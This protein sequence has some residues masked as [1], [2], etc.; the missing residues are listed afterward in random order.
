MGSLTQIMTNDKF[1]SAEHRVLASDKRDRMSV[2]VFVQPQNHVKVSVM[3]DLVPANKTAI[4]NDISW[5]DHQNYARQGLDNKLT[6]LALKR[7]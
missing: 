5:G 6:Q 2:M 1:K 3:H 7:C 4:Y